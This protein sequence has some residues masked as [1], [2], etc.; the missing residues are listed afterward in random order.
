MTEHPTFVEERRAVC[1]ACPEKN[2]VGLCNQC[3]CVV[4]LKTMLRSSECPIGC[5]GKEEK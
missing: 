2:P 5:W 1:A 3:G 4:F